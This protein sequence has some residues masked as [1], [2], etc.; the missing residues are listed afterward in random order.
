LAGLADA[1][2]RRTKPGL[3]AHERRLL[4]FQHRDDEFRAKRSSDTFERVESADTAT[5]LDP[6]DHGRR[7]PRSLGKFAVTHPGLHPSL[8]DEFAERRFSFGRYTRAAV[9]MTVSS[10][11]VF[12]SRVTGHAT[13]FTA[14]NDQRN[15]NTPVAMLT[16][17][18]L[19]DRLFELFR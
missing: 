16:F 2:P 7:G 10:F 19:L 8:L 12:P 11:D 6:R 17:E 18:V 14:D 5:T 9:R 1:S 13:I 3:G 15:P 4:P